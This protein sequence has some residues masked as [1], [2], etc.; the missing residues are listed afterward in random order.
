MRVTL[1]SATSIILYIEYL[2]L[3]SKVREV[4]TYLDWSLAPRAVR[5][6]AIHGGD[7]LRPSMANGRFNQ[8]KKHFQPSVT[9]RG[10]G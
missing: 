5:M 10:L 3:H 4:M 2:S 7:A 9:N 1:E 6:L 8:L